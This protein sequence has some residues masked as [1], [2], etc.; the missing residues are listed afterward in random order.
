MSMM[1]PSFL[2]PDDCIFGTLK[3]TH[4]SPFHCGT[5]QPSTDSQV[6]TLMPGWSIDLHQ[7]L[8][9]DWGPCVKFMSLLEWVCACSVTQK[10]PS[11]CRTKMSLPY[12][13]LDH[14]H[15]QT[16]HFCGIFTACSWYNIVCFLR[17][18]SSQMKLP[19]LSDPQK[20]TSVVN[21]ISPIYLF[22]PLSIAQTKSKT[23]VKF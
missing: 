14:L 15:L 5:S 17:M 23:L 2:R 20:S 11:D 1:S 16:S 13:P 19:F 7:G 10:F 4:A 3:K 9:S 18:T 8:A 22:T 6:S 12:W 21:L